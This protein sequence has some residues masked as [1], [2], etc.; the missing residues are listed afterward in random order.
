MTGFPPGILVAAI[1][2]AT[3]ELVAEE[4][5]PPVEVVEEEGEGEGPGWGE[6]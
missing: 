4:A 2:A 3:C 5:P 1:P 6:E